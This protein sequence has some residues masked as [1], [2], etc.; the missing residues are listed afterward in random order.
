MSAEWTRRKTAAAVADD[1]KKPSHEAAC[2]ANF[3]DS[4]EIEKKQ[5]PTREKSSAKPNTAR[6]S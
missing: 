5:A 4:V 6:R 3:N 1:G 2:P